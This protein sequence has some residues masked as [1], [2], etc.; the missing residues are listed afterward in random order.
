MTR[1]LQTIV[2]YVVAIVR[3]LLFL[4]FGLIALL[5]R[6]WRWIVR[7]RR[8]TNIFEEEPKDTCGKLPEA[9]VR[10]PDPCLYSQELLQSQGLPVTWNNPDIWIAPA[11][12][13][14]TVLPD[15]YHLEDDTDYIVSVRIHNASAT[16]P[17]IGARVR[18]H[19]RPWSFNSPDRVPVETDATGA[20]VV[21]FVNVPPMNSD[22]V[23]FNWHTP[24]LGAG[25]TSKHYCLQSTVD[26][27]LDTNVGNNMGQENTNVY[28]S[29]NP[30]PP[31]PGETITLTAPLF[32]PTDAVQR[33][34][35]TANTFAV[36]DG[37]EEY[38]LALQTTRAYAHHRD[39]IVDQLTTIQPV[40][41]S[42][43]I[44]WT[45][46]QFG[47]GRRGQRLTDPLSLFSNQFRLHPRSPVVAEKHRYDGYEQIREDIL[48]ADNTLPDGMWITVDGEDIGDGIQLDEGETREV[49]LEL[50]IPD[51]IVP[52]TTVPVNLAARTDDEVPLGGISV[53]LTVEEET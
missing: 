17:A 53:I 18:L 7:S 11:D 13:P 2:E 5:L 27:P 9:L 43:P 29:E 42:S 49:Q 26:H 48:A 52:G 20:E 44:R 24:P 46:G 39:S 8:E 6:L 30:G 45:T 3:L 41:R 16:D 25:E 4:L 33:V 40:F 28:R 10:R 36:G 31:H 51:D 50:K 23:E 19:Y 12:D 37:D 34:A 35:F 47:E 22:V 38:R 14:T 15:S 21:N 1:L 32:N